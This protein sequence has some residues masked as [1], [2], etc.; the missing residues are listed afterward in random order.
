MLGSLRRKSRSFIVWVVFGFLIAVFV[1]GFGTPASNKLSCGNQHAV[2]KVGHYELSKDDYQYAFRLVMREG[3]PPTLKAFMLDMLIRREILVEEAK[4]LGFQSAVTSDDAADDPDVVNM[5][6]HRKLLVLGYERDLFQLGGWPAMRGAK[7]RYHAS[8]DFNYE[9]FKKWVKWRLGLT[10]VKFMQEQ[11]RE[12]LAKQMSDTIMAS[13][14]IS[15]AEARAMYEERHTRLVLQTAVFE[16]SKYEKNVFATGS[17]LT[18]FLAD[19]KNAD[20]V[21]DLYKTRYADKKDFADQRRVRH[22]LFKVDKAADKAKVEE[23]RRVAMRMA[24]RLTP[25]TFA[26]QAQTLSQDDA[27]KGSGGLLGWVA[28]D[29]LTFGKPFAKAVFAFKDGTVSAPIRSDAGWHIVLVEGRRKGTWSLEQARRFIAYDMVVSQKALTMARSLADQSYHRLKAGASPDVVFA[30][31]AAGDAGKTAAASGA[32]KKPANGAVASASPAAPAAP[33]PELHQVTLTRTTTAVAGME[34][35]QD[36]VH[37]VWKL[38]D[39]D[40]LIGKV[41]E[42]RRG[43]KVAAFGIVRRKQLTKPD[44]KEFQAQKSELMARYLR[45]KQE[46]TLNRWVRAKCDAMAAKGEIEI[47]PNLRTIKYYPKGQHGEEESKPITIEY[48]YCKQLPQHASDT[49]GQ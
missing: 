49:F 8:K 47:A 13:V 18:A 17:E 40:P 5:I 29:D 41:I 21:A 27:S 25:A 15:N 48:H 3:A 39:K 35:V 23:V 26:Q 7:G 46:D 1:I 36:L 33:M 32:A 28:P 10:V 22:I 6:T 11:Q 43:G 31:D 38:T 30:K 16:R 37:R 44:W 2:G 34:E 12:L 9:H 45:T 4:K 14:L 24:R 19:K 20:K 42:I